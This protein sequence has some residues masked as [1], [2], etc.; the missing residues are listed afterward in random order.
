MRA[1][2]RFVQCLG[3]VMGIV[4]LAL[5]FEENGGWET[6]QP[7]HRNLGVACTALGAMQLT[8]LAWRP[9]KGERYRASW[10]FFHHWFGRS[11]AILAI[12]NIY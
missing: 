12:A 1:L 2:L 6:D 11:A 3:L 8:A 9:H 7:V 5:G 4:G 10:E